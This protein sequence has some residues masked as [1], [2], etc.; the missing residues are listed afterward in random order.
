[1]LCPVIYLAD[2]VVQRNASG[3]DG[4]ATLGLVSTGIRQTLVAS[5]SHG[6]DTS[7]SNQGVRESGLPCSPQ[8]TRLSICGCADLEILSVCGP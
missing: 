3:L 8:Q 5:S 4:D 1:M 6:N 7:G 2:F